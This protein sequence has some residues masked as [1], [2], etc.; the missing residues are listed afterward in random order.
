MYEHVT[1]C[2]AYVERGW[3]GDQTLLVLKYISYIQINHA[4]QRL[5]RS[6]DPYLCTHAETLPLDHATRARH[7]YFMYVY[8]NIGIVNALNT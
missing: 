7:K 5:L 1:L 4:K 2:N 6:H 3:V 8:K